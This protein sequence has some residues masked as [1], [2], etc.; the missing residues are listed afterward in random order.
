MATTITRYVNT[1]SSGGDGTTN[2]TSGASAAYASLQAC[3]TAEVA[4]RANLV[5]SDELLHIL[6]C[7]SAADTTVTVISNAWTTD[8]TRYIHVE[9]N[10]DHVNGAHYSTSW[11]D[12]TYRIM[13]SSNFGYALHNYTPYFRMTRI[14]IQNTH[15]TNGYSSYRHEPEENYAN[16]DSVFVSV[17]CRGAV[18]SVFGNGFQQRDGRVR[19]YNCL[20]YGN[21]RGFE[22]GY[23]PHGPPKADY[24]NCTSVGNLSAGW[25]T[26]NNDWSL[27]G[28]PTWTNCY[29]GGNPDGDWDD[30]AAAVTNVYTTCASSDGTVGS[31]VAYATGSGAYFTNVTAGSVD[32][33]IGASS[34]LR[35]VGTDLSGTFTTDIAGQTRPT[36]ANTWDIGVYEYVQP[37][38]N[39]ARIWI[40]GF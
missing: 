40:G 16:D 29:G 28:V 15:E 10:P 21:R 38:G 6:C 24:Y 2:A 25:W 22:I 7:G 35:D 27:P 11:D 3:I 26:S 17:I 23:G 5:A 36:G 19:Y 31:T 9:G 12:T 39:D 34:A 32:V 33:S 13:A 18:Y 30:Q 8:A 14:Q 4:V 20:S 37:A 1:A